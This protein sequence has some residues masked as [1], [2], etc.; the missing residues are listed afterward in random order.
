MNSVTLLYEQAQKIVH[1]DR[2]T[3]VLYIGDLDTTGR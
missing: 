2:P 3:V 1:A